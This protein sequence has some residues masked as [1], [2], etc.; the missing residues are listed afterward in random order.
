MGIV[1]KGQ[2]GLYRGHGNSILCT[3]PSR[4]QL[5]GTSIDNHVRRVRAKG[6]HQPADELIGVGNRR[7]TSRD[8]SYKTVTIG[9]GIRH[10]SI[11]HALNVDI[12]LRLVKASVE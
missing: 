2:C 7:T 3:D 5:D 10:R 9:K 4:D 8:L 12:Q 11:F 1:N 6:K